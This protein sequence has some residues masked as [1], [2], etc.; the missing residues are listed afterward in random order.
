MSKDRDKSIIIRATLFWLL[1]VY[2]FKNLTQFRVFFFQ[3]FITKI[4]SFES[5]CNFYGHLNFDSPR[6]YE[7][8]KTC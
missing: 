4:L 5:N 8:L 6:S 3:L 7:F 1:L 2:S